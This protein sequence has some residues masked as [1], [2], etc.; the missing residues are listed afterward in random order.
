MDFQNLSAI[1]CDFGMYSSI[2]Q[3]KNY[4]T[5]SRITLP[6]QEFSRNV[7][8]QYLLQV[9]FMASSIKISLS[10]SRLTMVGFSTLF[11]KLDLKTE[12]ILRLNMSCS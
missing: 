1:L 3:L 6:T 9:S 12:T 4:L 8:L 7:P 5:S 2:N 10:V 11:F